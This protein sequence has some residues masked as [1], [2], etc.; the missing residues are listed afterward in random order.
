MAKW[1]LFEPRGGILRWRE[2]NDGFANH[3]LVNHCEDFGCYSF[4][5]IEINLDVVVGEVEVISYEEYKAECPD[6]RYRCE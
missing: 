1:K 3:L 4:Q 2:R 6:L 5:P